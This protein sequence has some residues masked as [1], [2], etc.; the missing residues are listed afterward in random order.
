[1]S[2]KRGGV[3]I[4]VVNFFYVILFIFSIIY[5]LY[6]YMPQIVLFVE[7]SASFPPVLIV[8][9]ALCENAEMT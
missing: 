9:R 5:Y 6:E 3:S 4:E 1:M 2:G 8:A 7:K